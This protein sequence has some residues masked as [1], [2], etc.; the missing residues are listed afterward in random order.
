MGG[1]Y[2]NQLGFNIADHRFDFMGRLNPPVMRGFG[3]ATHLACGPQFTTLRRA[4]F[5]TLLGGLFF[6]GEQLTMPGIHRFPFGFTVR[7]D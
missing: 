7:G 3:I 5:G 2:G 1:D 6:C 4:Y